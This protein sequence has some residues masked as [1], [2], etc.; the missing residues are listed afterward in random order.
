MSRIF[1]FLDCCPSELVSDARADDL[2]LA[3]EDLE[4]AIKETNIHKLCSPLVISFVQGA[5]TALSAQQFLVRPNRPPFLQFQLWKSYGNLHT[6]CADH[7]RA[8]MDQKLWVLLLQ[9]ALK[10]LP[11]E[12]IAPKFFSDPAIYRILNTEP[13]LLQWEQIGFR[14]FLT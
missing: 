4:N 12:E 2:T 7:P 5:A 8:I 3:A 6:Q 14:R 13:T 1:G 11:L 10:K 9:A